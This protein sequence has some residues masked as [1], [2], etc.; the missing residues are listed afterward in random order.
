MAACNIINR[1]NIAGNIMWYSSYRLTHWSGE[2]IILLSVSDA[3]APRPEVCRIMPSYVILI[4]VISSSSTT[5]PA[6][7]F[8]A[9]DP[10]KLGYG[11]VL[12]GAVRRACGDVFPRALL[13]LIPDDVYGSSIYTRDDSCETLPGDASPAKCYIS[14]CA[15]WS[16]AESKKS[17]ENC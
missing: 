12:A 1:N 4:S 17:R 3:Q 14:G 7:K 11:P 15:S 6:A 9:F 10:M 16:S 8:R 2:T 13:L 5:P